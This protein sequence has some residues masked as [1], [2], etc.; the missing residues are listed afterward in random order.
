MQLLC[1]TSARHLAF[2]SVLPALFSLLAL[3]LVTCPASSANR[4]LAWL[5]LPA[6]HLEEP[7][8]ILLISLW[9]PLLRY[10]G[11]IYLLPCRKPGPPCG[12]LRR[13]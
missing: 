12:M 8:V 13:R 10:A 5:A 3:L 6:V 7:M 11:L 2:Y 1:L 4:C 9:R